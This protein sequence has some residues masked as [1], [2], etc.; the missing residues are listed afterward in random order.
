M[1][2]TGPHWNRL[3]YGM[4]WAVYLV[5]CADGSL[6]TGVATDVARRVAQH[7]AGTGA[8]YTR[9]RRPVT[10]VHQEPAAD[11]PAALVTEPF[12]S[13]PVRHESKENR[14][15]VSAGSA[16]GRPRGDDPPAGELVDTGHSHVSLIRTGMP[17]MA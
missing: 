10:L 16:A 15:T 14:M 3:G 2:P 11:R 12:P 4:S 5:R 1:T 9:A 7:N 6:Y 17:A 8:R 13:K